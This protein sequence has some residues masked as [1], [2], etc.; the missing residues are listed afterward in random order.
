MALDSMSV[1][2]LVLLLSL[3]THLAISSLWSAVEAYS[4]FRSPINRNP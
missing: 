3:A 2:G 1:A 4:A